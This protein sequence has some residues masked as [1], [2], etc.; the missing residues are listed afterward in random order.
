MNQTAGIIILV[1]IAVITASIVVGAYW[2]YGKVRENTFCQ[3]WLNSLEQRRAE[4]EG[5][6]WKE[7]SFNYDQYNAE[8]ADYNKECAY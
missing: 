1:V 6:F 3:N 2:F 8:V 4:A 7:L 5:S